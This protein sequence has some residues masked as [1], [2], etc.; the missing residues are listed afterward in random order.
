MD[1]NLGLAS[2]TPHLMAL[3]Q[4]ILDMIFELAFAGSGRLT[5]IAGVAWLDKKGTAEAISRNRSQGSHIIR[6]YLGRKVDEF[7][8]S[9]TFFV[10]AAAAYMRN[11]VVCGTD[12]VS[13]QL[14]TSTG[15]GK[16]WLRTLDCKMATL[17]TKP[18][19]TLRSL[20]ISIG[21]YQFES[22]GLK[23]SDDELVEADFA[24][25]RFIDDLLGIRGLKAFQLHDTGRHRVSNPSDRARWD[26]NV[27]RLDTLIRSKV[28]Q[29][30]AENTST[31]RASGVHTS[32]ALY[33]G[34]LVSSTG[35]KLLSAS[36]ASLYPFKME[37]SRESTSAVSHPSQHLK[38]KIT[39]SDV[40]SSIEGL[41]SLLDTNGMAFVAWVEEMKGLAQR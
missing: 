41:K 24:K 25:I 30:K 10:T 27:Q 7:M 13:L 1:P 4:E 5:I 32:S 26:R 9:K 34:S 35:S 16:A 39:A 20:V 3:P 22:V 21:S 11:Q 8:V 6:P 23:P 40:P 17:P 2:E 15:I 18:I 38:N 19:L 36:S 12:L 14:C 33:P 28:L 37:P 31:Y 29:P